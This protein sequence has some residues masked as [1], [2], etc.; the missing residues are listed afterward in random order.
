MWH[1][2]TIINHGNKHDSFLELERILKTWND[3]L[4]RSTEE[5]PKHSLDGGR[6]ISYE[7]EGKGSMHTSPPPHEAE[8]HDMQSKGPEPSR[9]FNGKHELRH[10]GSSQTGFQIPGPKTVE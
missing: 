10:T 6:L 3:P 4:Q 9:Q 1:K 7:R 8:I 2:Y 5:N